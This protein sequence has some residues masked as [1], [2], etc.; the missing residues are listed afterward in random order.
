MQ[1]PARPPRPAAGRRSPWPTA[2]ATWRRSWRGARRRSAP[3]ISGSTS[4]TSAPTRFA[5][6]RR[7]AALDR[8]VAARPRTSTPTSCSSPAATP[9]PSP[10]PI[11]L[12][13]QV[14]QAG[15]DIGAEAFLNV[16]ML[17]ADRLPAAGRGAELR[18]R[19][20]PPT[21]ACCRS[22][23]SG[24]HTRREGATQ[25]RSRCSSALLRVDPEQPAGA[26]AA[27]H[28]AHDARH[29]SR[30]RA[31]RRCASRRRRSRR[32][33]RCRASR[34]SPRE[35]GLDVHGLSGGAVIEDFDGDGLLDVMRLGDRLRR[36][37]ALLPQHRRR[38]L[39]G[40]RPRAAASPA[41]PA[42]STWSTPTTTTTAWLDVLVLRGA[43]LGAAGQFPVSLLRNHGDGT[44]ADVTRAA[45]LAVD[46]GRRRPRPGSTTTA[47][48][49]STSSSATSPTVLPNDRFAEPPVP[50]QPRRHVH[51]RRRG[52]RASTSS[53]S[54]RAAVARR[55]RQRRPA[56][57]LPVAGAA[58]RTCCST[59]TGPQ[60][61]GGWRFTDVDRQ[62]RRRRSRT[63]ASRRCSSTTTTT[64][65]STSSSRG[66][67]RTAPR[68]S[69]PTTSASPT[70]ADRARLYRNRGDGTFADVTARG[71][72]LTRCCSPW[73]PTSATSTTTAGSTSTSAPATP[74]S[75]RSCPNRMFRN[76][77]GKRFQDVTTAGNFGHLQKGH[78]I[79]FGDLDNDGDQDVFEKMGGA[80]QAD[81]AYSVLLREPARGRR[82]AGAEGRLGEPRARRHDRE[83]RRHRRAGHGAPADAGRPAPPASRRRRPAAAS[84]RRRC[85]SSSASATR[86]RSPASTSAGRWPG[87]ARRR[88]RRRRSAASSP[89]A[90]T[91]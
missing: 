90:T 12:L 89:A 28:R 88:R 56:R 62:G 6:G 86:P 76:D 31:A 18:Q 80:Y 70:K 71:R 54:S 29:L 5:Q 68:T 64:A 37:D 87:P 13:E 40:A 79:A 1:T 85:A 45:G 23:A 53:A 84:G 25:A 35:V 72:P 91:C 69:P 21:R 26:L 32:R 77:G 42:G 8:R 15:P 34:T 16:L 51:R 67:L 22:R 39:R 52:G 43:W 49:G 82:D 38:H 2:R 30:R 48:A 61:G 19:R 50:Q 11:V 46:C 63:T 3:A 66:Y 7:R 81:R 27:E 75:A 20:Q 9:T 83:P 41:S 58:R 47:T 74:T 17:R 73:A 14:D 10:R 24:V 65:G 44:F 57:P 33:I 36:P 55:L 60:P 59:T 78:G 4:T